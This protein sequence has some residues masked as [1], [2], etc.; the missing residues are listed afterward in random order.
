MWLAARIKV[1]DHSIRENELENFNGRGM[2]RIN[3]SA[4]EVQI[5]FTMPNAVKFHALRRREPTWQPIVTIVPYQFPKRRF[6]DDHQ[7]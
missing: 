3:N 5:C 6:R 7:T 4:L 2:D 1:I